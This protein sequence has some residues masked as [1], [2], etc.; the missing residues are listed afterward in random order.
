[1]RVKRRTAEARIGA[2]GPA[3][4][5]QAPASPLCAC[6]GAARSQNLRKRAP[7]TL[8]DAPSASLTWGTSPSTG[9]SVRRLPLW[10]SSL[11]VARRRLAQ[12][13][14]ELTIRPLLPPGQLTISSVPGSSGTDLKAAEGL[15]KW[16]HSEVRRE[17]GIPLDQ[18][19]RYSW[20]YP[21]CPD[22]SEHEKVWR[23]LDL[24]V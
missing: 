24:W 16:L 14:V 17:L 19:R 3:N 12:I 7:V 5:P 8:A 22:Q 4:R 23:L 2:G 15:A 21:A 1:V 9:R 18:G 20:G 10:A 11:T 6:V 13:L